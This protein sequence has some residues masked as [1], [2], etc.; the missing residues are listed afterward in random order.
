MPDLVNQPHSE[1]LVYEITSCLFSP[2]LTG[3]PLPF[4]QIIIFSSLPLTPLSSTQLLL[5]SLKSLFRLHES[6]AC[7]G[8]LP[9]R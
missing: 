2:P 4:H 7:L 8:V 6:H 9:M 3:L 1:S 5:P